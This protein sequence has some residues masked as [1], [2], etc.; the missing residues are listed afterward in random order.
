MKIHWIVLLALAPLAGYTATNSLEEPVF[1]AYEINFADPSNAVEIVRNLVG[2]AGKVFYDNATRR[3][4]VMAP[5]NSHTSI[6]DLVQQ[7]NVPPKNVSVTVRFLGKGRNRETGASISGTGS[8]ILDGNGTRSGFAMQPKVVHQSSESTSR[9]TQQLLVA[10]GRQASLFIGEEV[11]YVEWL[12]EYG[13]R[14]HYFEERIVWQRVGASLV[15][16]PFVV[17]DGPTIRL[18]VTPELSGLVDKNPYR[19]RFSKVATEVFVND[20][21]P[22]PLGGLAEKNDFYSRFLIGLDSSGARQ[23]LDIELTARII[24][25]GGPPEW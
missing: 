12:M 17:G 21:I 25:P 13:R 5:G 15:I 14:H 18:R 8:I 7:L 16:E 22:F 4:I 23:T 10:S 2:P 24:P 6:A 9:T 11:P 1:K 20:G 3:I 19:V